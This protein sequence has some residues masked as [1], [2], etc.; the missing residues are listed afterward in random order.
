V[1]ENLLYFKLFV[2]LFLLHYG[3]GIS[4]AGVLRTAWLFFCHKKLMIKGWI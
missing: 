3:L 1:V 2:A 4:W